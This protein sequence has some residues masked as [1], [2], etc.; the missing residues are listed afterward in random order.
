MLGLDICNVLGAVV[1]LVNNFLPSIGECCL[2]VAVP[3]C[4][5]FPP[6]VAE[7]PSLVGPMPNPDFSALGNHR[8]I[9][10]R[11]AARKIGLSFLALSVDAREFHTN[12]GGCAGG[13]VVATGAHSAKDLSAQTARP[14]TRGSDYRRYEGA[15]TLYHF[16]DFLLLSS[17]HSIWQ[18]AAFVLPPSCHGL[19]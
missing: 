11:T 9:A 2:P 3:F 19:M 5:V 7:A 17:L 1:C 4:F 13:R 8:V 16:P 6:R 14:P 18:L 15:A 12:V 10:I